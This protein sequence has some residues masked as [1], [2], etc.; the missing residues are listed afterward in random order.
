MNRQIRIRATATAHASTNVVFDTIADHLSYPA[1]TQVD[2]ASLETEGDPIPNGLGAV[3]VFTSAGWQPVK[4]EVNH[5]WPPHLFGYRVIEGGPVT[6]H[7]G[8]I[9]LDEADDATRIV[10]HVTANPLNEAIADVVGAL[11]PLAIQQMV[12][13]LVVEAERRAETTTITR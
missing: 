9:V 12:D 4:E 7:Q 2:G 5:F 1:W 6:D 8:I 11:L 3:R 13:E 10:W